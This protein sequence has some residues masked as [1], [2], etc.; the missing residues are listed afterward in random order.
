MSV[1]RQKGFTITELV[2]FTAATGFLMF[3]L[4]GGWVLSLNT[5]SYRDSARTLA[6]TLE[7]QF[8]ATTNVWNDR[9]GNEQCS[10]STVTSSTPGATRGTT[11]C[12]IMG[13]Y[14][15][16]NG[17]AGQVESASIVGSGSGVGTTDRDIILSYTP[18][19][20]DTAI[21]PL[22]VEPI[23]W[24]ARAYRANDADAAVFD[25]VFVIVRSPATGLVYTYSLARGEGPDLPTVDEVISGT[26]ST[27]QQVICLDPGAPVS[28]PRAGVVVGANAASASAIRVVA[29]GSVGC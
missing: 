14:V 11:D 29:D 13:R 1:S 15:H 19:R 4:M 6:A 27:E 20:V 26:G 24:S 16:V 25:R 8:T 5:Q 7:A 28:G 12:V 3:A 18:T 9:G 2:L 22:Q 23:R 10:A 17:P 21:L